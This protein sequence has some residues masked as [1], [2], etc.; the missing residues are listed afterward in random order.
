WRPG[1]RVVLTGW[2]HGESVFGGLAQRARVDAARLVRIPAALDARSAMCIGTAGFTAM[3]AVMS[4][5]ANGV[6]PDK[7]EVLV[8]GAGGG[9]GGFAVALLRKAGFC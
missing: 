8:T 7:G 4:L 1:D 9:V 2:G 3:L 6:T 5:E